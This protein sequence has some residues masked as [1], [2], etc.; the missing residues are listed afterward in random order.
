[1]EIHGTQVLYLEHL[2]TINTWLSVDETNN[3][4]YLV[5][6]TYGL[7]DGEMFTHFRTRIL[8][9]P[10]VA[11]D[12]NTLATQLETSLN[13]SNKLVIST[14]KVTR[15]LSDPNV[16]VNSMSLLSCCTIT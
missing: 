1:M 2:S 7:K 12:A 15:T 8:E 6:W 16:T 13:G 11:Y 14:Y 9:I 4:F 3:K 5:E 10:I